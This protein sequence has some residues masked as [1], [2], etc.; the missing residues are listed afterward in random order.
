MT[1]PSTTALSPRVILI[2]DSDMARWPQDLYPTTG[3]VLNL[4]RNGATLATTR[5]LL[6]QPNFL[7]EATIQ[8]KQEQAAATLFFVVCVGENDLGS[9][10]LSSLELSLLEKEMDELL[11]ILLSSSPSPAAGPHEK[12]RVSVLFLGPKLEPWLTNDM[13]ARQAYWRLSQLQEQT[14]RQYV[15]VRFVDCVTMFCTAD[16]AHAAGARLAGRAIPDPQY[17]DA[18]DRLHL[19]RDGYAVWQRLVDEAIDKF[20]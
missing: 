9:G 10:V 8:H 19:S 3:T 11:R 5:Q 15:N 7:P 17:F 4:G 2:G 18:T 13:D 20:R 1:P 14:C 16:T 12:Q 6:A